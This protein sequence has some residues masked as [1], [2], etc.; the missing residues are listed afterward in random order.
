[1]T[2]FYQPAR[3]LPAGPPYMDDAYERQ[4]GGSITA[5]HVLGVLRR[6]YKLVLALTLAG[7]A[8][9]AYLASK[10]PP[11]YRAVATI[12]LAGERRA[13][14]GDI[15]S[16]TPELGRSA[17]PM[18]SLTQL[19]RSYSVMG[20]VV[21]SL[22]LQ[23]VSRT[24]EFGTSRLEN[25]WVEPK[26]AND[27][28]LVT[29]YQNGVKA[30]LGDREARARYREVLDLGTARFSV[31]STPNVPTAELHV[32]PREMAIDQLMNGVQVA[33]R[34]ATDVIDVGYYSSNPRLAQRVVNTTV[35]VFKQLSILTAKQKSQRR[36]EFLESQL[37][38]TDSMLVR[39]QAE[40]AAFRS[41]QQLAS[42]S[43][44]L[45]DQQ[46]AMMAI[47]ARRA[48]LEADRATFATLVTQLKKSGE[49]GEGE[50]IRALAASPAMADNPRVGDYYRQLNTYQ[51]R[52]DSM[53]TG[54]WKAAPT[55]PDLIQLK[56][57]IST[58]KD[59]LRQAI[60][61]HVT[62]LDA[63]IAA[64]GNLRARSGAAL[65][66]LPAMAEEE[67]RL[68][69]RVQSLTSASDQVRKDY[70]NA[71]MAEEVEAGDVD[72][73]DLAGTPY[74]PVSGAALLKL[75]LGL[76]LGLLLGTGGA[77]LL[78]ALNTSIRKPE[79]LEIALHV[80]GLAVIPRLTAGSGTSP[81]RVGGFLRPGKKAQ[82]DSKQASA[83]SLRTVTQ[84][85][86]IG[87]EAF[88]M[89]RTSLVWCEQGDNMKT[90][91]VTS[92]APGEGKTLTS[93]NLS[94]TFAYD[95]LRVLLIDCDIRRPRL[96]GMFQV[97][98]SPGLMELL[99]PSYNGSDAAQSLT[100]NPSSGRTDSGRPVTEVIRPTNVRGLSLLTCGALPTNP[101]N[102]LSG[103]RM[104]VLLQ[105]LAKSFDLV[106][107]DTPPV[108]ATADAGILASLADGVLLV[109]R[110][111]QTDRLAAKR[112]HQQLVNVGARVVG[113]VL[114]D[115]GGEVSQ[116]GDYYY[117]YDYAAEEQ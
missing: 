56:S 10:T 104:R 53:T 84:P 27:T 57:L 85:F 9:G 30:R 73:V 97:P 83:S 12:R 34:T 89:L 23:L 42:T 75:G 92:A 31:S 52:L 19:V 88:R 111:G 41:R 21:D 60:S 67:A 87:V 112:A 14:T 82:L 3:Q 22:G 39:A 13:L 102:L 105:E 16:P 68:L 29:F 117:P 100:L 86:S 36:R 95:G 107:L 71:R 91:V 49:A 7:I 6:R 64:L 110:A 90:L 17:D 28:I 61:S 70:Q 69:G 44:A 66:V 58:T 72:V 54:P 2:E 46:R 55:N 33:P 78:E 106:I 77:F 59:Q 79:D 115:P 38:Q 80:P 113:T 37:K 1:M 24:P 50:A 48:E 11:S 96:H 63:R 116:Y 103:V 94:V 108:L 18:L 35:S 76:V 114:N 8:A 40:L 101:S 47:D 81:R 98:R 99:T 109:V 25:V 20:A 65:Q 45:E 32:L 4:G 26:S 93:A 51:Y 74:A 62:T 43:S 5:G 15:E